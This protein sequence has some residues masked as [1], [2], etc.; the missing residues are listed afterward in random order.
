MLERAGFGELELLGP[1]GSAPFAL[2]DRRLVVRA[3]AIDQP[4]GVSAPAS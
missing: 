1:D 2:G 3:R 4:A